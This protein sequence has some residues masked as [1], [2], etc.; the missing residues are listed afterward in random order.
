M[1]REFDLVC[2]AC[3]AG[4]R[5]TGAISA[6]AAEIATFMAA[7]RDHSAFTITAVP[8]TAGCAETES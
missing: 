5:L 7:H 8:G 2:G 3:G 1:A 6:M 4:Y